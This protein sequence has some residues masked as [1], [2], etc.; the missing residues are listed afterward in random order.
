MQ[1]G[2]STWSLGPE[3][4]PMD[5]LRC[6]QSAGIELVEVWNRDF[7]LNGDP[8]EIKK[9]L[10]DHGLTFYS[11][12]TTV[13]LGPEDPD[14]RRKAHDT[15]LKEIEF[16]ARCEGKILVVHAAV[17]N[18]Y[19]K[20]AMDRAIPLAAQE[21]VLMCVEN[22]KL[23]SVDCL[24]SL[25]FHYSDDHLRFILDTGHLFF[26]K[27]DE[28]NDILSQVVHRTAPY[29][30]HTHCQDMGRDGRDHEAVGKG[31][32]DWN[33]FIADLVH[34]GYSGCLTIEVQRPDY[35]ESTLHARDTLVAAMKAVQEIR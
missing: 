10:A 19:N 20:A 4:D 15:L 11:F 32:I 33:R 21:G 3:M 9:H 1:I 18:D 23:V 34:V 5:K 13:N 27:M 6:I 35:H 22:G 28:G 24:E 2:C 26:D 29:L 7:S 25:I 16:V 8:T 31:L 14:E 12:H 30:R 17:D